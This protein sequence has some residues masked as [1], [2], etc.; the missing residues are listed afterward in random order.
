[1]SKTLVDIDDSVLE[2]AL[3]LSGIATKKG[4]VAAALEQMVRRLELDRYTEF[5]HSG[6]LDGLADA[7]VIRSAQR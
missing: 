2:R 4:V 6:A 1:M 3:K 7:E 5:V